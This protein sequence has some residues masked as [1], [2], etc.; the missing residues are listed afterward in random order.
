MKKSFLVLSLLVG[1]AF[2]T[3]AQISKG[4]VMVSG[5]SDLSIL[6]GSTKTE[7]DG[8]K[9]DR[10]S[11]SGFSL[12]PQLS[13]F[14]TDNLA[15]GAALNLEYQDADDNDATTFFIGP[16]ARYY[17]GGDKIRPFG[18]AMIGLGSA[19]W[20]DKYRV[21]GMNLNAGVSYFFNDHVAL[22]GAMGYGYRGYTNSDDSNAKI[23]DNNFGVLLSFT[24]LF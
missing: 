16:V 23:K 5:S 19:K 6:F 20:G 24:V 4:R 11:T 9:V 18:E 10:Y 3:H 21:F 1:M 12:T 8:R 14:F 22:D 17:F 15:I 2:G 13:Y 7:Y